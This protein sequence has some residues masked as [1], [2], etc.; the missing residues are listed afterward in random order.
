MTT[1]PA[2]LTFDQVFNGVVSIAFVMNGS[3]NSYPVGS[4]AGPAG[5]GPVTLTVAFDSA[6]MPPADYSGLLQGQ[7]KIV[8]AGTATSGSTGFNSSNS[9]DETATIDATFGFVAYE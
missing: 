6:S 4:V 8:L 1:T 2:G 5:A 3:G 9:S 7:F